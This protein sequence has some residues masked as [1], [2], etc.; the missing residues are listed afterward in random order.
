MASKAK[1]TI[2]ALAKQSM[3]GTNKHLTNMTQ[4]L[5]VGSSF[6]PAQINDKMQ[7]IVDLRAT[8]DA[9]RA[10]LK[11]A[12][13]AEKA[14]MP[15]L[16]TFVGAFE[17][18]IK[19]AFAN[20]PDV[21]ADFGLHP[22]ARGQP[23][24]ETKLVAVAKRAATRAARHTLSAKKKRNIKGDVVGITVTPVATP[25]PVATKPSNPTTPATST[26]GPA[27]STPPHTT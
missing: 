17:S 6:T 5:L 4:I 12:V 15:N 8:V 26:G 11:A 24:V 18:F 13:A 23:T 27:S 7:R 20:Q 19:A 21:L 14:E 9:A 3:A 22:K 2:V 16:H 10:S 1:N 25:Q